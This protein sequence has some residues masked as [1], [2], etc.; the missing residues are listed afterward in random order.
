MGARCSKQSAK[1]Q[2]E[3][4]EAERLKKLEEQAM[5]E[6][7]ERRIKREREEAERLL[8]EQ[9]EEERRRQIEE[10]LALEQAK[11]EEEER[12]KQEESLAPVVVP[13]KTKSLSIK[14]DDHISHTSSISHE[15]I[16]SKSSLGSRKSSLSSR[17]TGRKDGDAVEMPTFTPFSMRRTDEIAKYLI[18]KCGCALSDTHNNTNCVICQSVDLSDA[19]LIA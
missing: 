10:Q 8:R 11:R 12:L 7:E 14:S 1:K 5:A 19:P 6:V 16:G 3:Q 2:M 17:T 9:E 4:D 15:S 13:L 18:S